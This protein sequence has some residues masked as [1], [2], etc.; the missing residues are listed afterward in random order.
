MRGSPPG[1]LTR[2]FQDY[3][4]LIYPK[5]SKSLNTKN[6]KTTKGDFEGNV[7]TTNQQHFQHVGLGMCLFVFGTFIKVDSFG[8]NTENDA[9][10]CAKLFG[11][12]TEV[13][14]GVKCRF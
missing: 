13:F 2:L 12:T 11:P 4:G 7:W 8:P 5:M 1:A 14:Y 3:F 9:T 10:V 6:R